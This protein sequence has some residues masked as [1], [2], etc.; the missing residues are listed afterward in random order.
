MSRKIAREAAMKLI[1]QME[2]NSSSADE[3]LQNY[4]E[5]VDDEFV[6]E[7]IDY[8]KDCVM[9][10]EREQKLIDSYIERFA[11]GW[12]INRVGKVDL[13]IMRLSIYEMLHMEDVPGAVS[14]NEAVNIAKKYC[15]DNSPSFIN[16]VLDSVF[17][18]IEGN[19]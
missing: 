6:E 19:A 17:K 13:A 10:V 15:G 9:G 7:N 5:N 3:V 18:E 8:I 14:I 16:G 1:Y 11:H 2:I 12:K 4:I